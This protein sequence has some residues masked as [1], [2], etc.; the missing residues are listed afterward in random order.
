MVGSDDESENPNS[1][2]CVDYSECTEW[3]CFTAVVGKDMGN[4]PKSWE[5]QDINFWVPK[6]SE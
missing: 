4:G 1:N 6:E 5:D 2:Y 3:F